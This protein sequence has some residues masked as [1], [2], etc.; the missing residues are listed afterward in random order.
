MRTFKILLLLGLMQCVLALPGLW[1]P[2]YL[3]TPVGLWL[4]VPYFVPYI[5]HALGVPGMLQNNGACG[6]GWCAPTAWGW[7]LMG[8]VWLLVY[9][10]IASLIAGFQ[11]RRQSD[12][13]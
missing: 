6:W 10:G 5:A 11:E 9:G 8:C 4:V 7:L 1:W 2:R 12:Q 3:D 13:A